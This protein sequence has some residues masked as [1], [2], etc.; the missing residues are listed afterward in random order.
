MPQKPPLPVEPAAVPRQTPVRPN[1]AVTRQHYRDRVLSVRQTNGPA[2]LGT[3]DARRH[4]AVGCR[5]ARRNRAQFVPHLALEWCAAGCDF[6]FFY[7]REVALEVPVEQCAVAKWIMPACE[8]RV[9]I[10]R[11]QLLPHAFFKIA[12]VQSA[13]RVPVARDE[14]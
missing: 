13:H 12:E 4:F 11:L 3:A 9:G 10:A 14:D 2:C 5:A 6:D 1:D 8:L 7:R